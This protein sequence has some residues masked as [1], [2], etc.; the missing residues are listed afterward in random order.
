V[1]YI[2]DNPHAYNAADGLAWDFGFGNSGPQG[3]NSPNPSANNYA[4][5]IEINGV[6]T[7]TSSSKTGVTKFTVHGKGNAL[8]NGASAVVTSSDTTF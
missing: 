1:L 2:H 4:N 7:V 8:V 3:L 6:L 5:S